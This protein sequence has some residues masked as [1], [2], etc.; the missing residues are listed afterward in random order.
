MEQCISDL[1]DQGMDDAEDVCQ[2]LWEEHSYKQQVRAKTRELLRRVDE[3]IARE[4]EASAAGQARRHHEETT[5]NFTAQAL[6]HQDPPKK[7]YERTTPTWRGVK[8]PAFT[9]RGKKIY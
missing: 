2:I 1:E 8:L 5:A 3:R 6:K 4:Y 9:W 7:V